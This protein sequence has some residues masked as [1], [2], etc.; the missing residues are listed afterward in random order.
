MAVGTTEL[1]LLLEQIAILLLL[2]VT[3]TDG[4]DGMVTNTDGTDG[5]YGY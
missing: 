1:K 3:N 2:V 4:T 5:T